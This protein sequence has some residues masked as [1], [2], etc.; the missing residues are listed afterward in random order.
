VTISDQAIGDGDPLVQAYEQMR[1]HVLGGQRGDSHFGL[2]L[3]LREGVASFI[4]RCSAGVGAARPAVHRE[5][6]GPAP[7]GSDQLHAG[8]VRV[9]ASMVIAGRQEMSA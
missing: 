6:P 4:E 5:Q 1:S 8:I 3:L 7:L 9:L 2:V